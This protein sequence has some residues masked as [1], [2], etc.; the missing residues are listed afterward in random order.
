MVAELTFLRRG[1][2]IGPPGSRAPR[3]GTG[4]RPFALTTST[5]EAIPVQLL[6]RAPGRERLEALRH[7]PVQDEVE[8]VRVAFRM[9]P[10]P[11]LGLAT[12]TLMEPRAEQAPDP[13]VVRGRSLINRFVEV[14][15]DATGALTLRDR[16]TGESFRDLVRLEDE[17]DA[18]DL[19]T[20]SPAGG[21]GARR[22]SGTVHVRRLATG[23]LVA[24]IEIRTTLRLRSIARASSSVRS[25]L[26]SPMS[27]PW[28]PAPAVS[29]RPGSMI[30]RFVPRSENSPLM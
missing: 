22:T 28:R 20:F 8:R 4:Y 11:G 18:G 30:S 6:G 19:Y 16:E 1:V 2:P 29:E 9:P 3:H 24:A 14:G 25:R 10:V 17:A 13:V 12:L 26:V 15:V 7:Y 21:A 27:M 5:G 23:P